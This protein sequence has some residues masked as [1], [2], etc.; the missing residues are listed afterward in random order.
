MATEKQ[1][2]IFYRPGN[3]IS[4]SNFFSVEEKVGKMDRSGTLLSHMAVLFAAVLAS[5]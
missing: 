2:P 1:P 3:Q 4:W 5:C